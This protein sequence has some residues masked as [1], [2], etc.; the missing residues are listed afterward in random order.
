MPL[1]TH[2]IA[3]IHSVEN[4]EYLKYLENVHSVCIGAC[5]EAD[6]TIIDSK[7]HSFGEGLGVT[8]IVILAESHLSIHTWPELNFFSL[9][10]Y[11]CGEKD[12]MVAVDFILRDFQ[13]RHY[14]IQIIKRGNIDG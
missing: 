4:P 1:G 7:F 12:P 2:I 3:D 10:V 8:G 11:S 5:R 13:A 9:D 6:L 14:N